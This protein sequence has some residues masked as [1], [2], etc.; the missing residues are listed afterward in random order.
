[1]IL[2]VMSYPKH[3]HITQIS[4]LHAIKHIPNITEIAIIWDDTHQQKPSASL[5]EVMNINIPVYMFPWS[6]IINDPQVDGWLG[7]QLIKLHLDTILK[8]DFVILDGDLIINQDVNPKNITYANALPRQ[9]PK[10]KH[11]NEILGLGSY[12]F[13][14]CPFMY[15]ES[16]WLK[17]IRQLCEIHSHTTLINRF[18]GYRSPMFNEWELIATYIFQV[19][20]LPRKIEYFN[21]RSVKSSNFV[22]EYTN[23]ENFVL[24]GADDL[25]WQFYKNNDVFIDS[26]LMKELG[27]N[28]C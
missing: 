22:S 4:I 7:Q 14:S 10:Y 27:Y 19:L 6:A 26:K 12:D 8:N 28:S 25:N 20:K 9:H 15:V 2:A 18:V 24:D 13:G 17:Q 3:Y 5:N 16:A 1:M 23:F 11:I 21:R